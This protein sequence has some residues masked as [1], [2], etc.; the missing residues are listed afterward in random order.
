M[1]VF[2]VIAACWLFAAALALGLCRM[3][4][5]GSRIQ[6]VYEDE[7]EEQRAPGVEAVA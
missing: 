1:L 2:A 5:V 6:V 4:A 3:A 7:A